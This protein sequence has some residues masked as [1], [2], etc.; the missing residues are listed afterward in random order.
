MDPLRQRGGKPLTAPCEAI[1]GCSN[2]QADQVAY[3]VERHEGPSLA[4]DGI[5]Q[6]LSYPRHRLSRKEKLDGI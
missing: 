3:L 2:T 6:N 5:R 1:A 4:W